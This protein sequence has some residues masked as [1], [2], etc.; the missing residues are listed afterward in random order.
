MF[1]FKAGKDGLLSRLL[2]R[3]AKSQATPS[4]ERISGAYI[5][6]QLP[7]HQ[8]HNSVISGAELNTL[9]EQSIEMKSR[10]AQLV[11]AKIIPETNDIQL[12]ES[13]NTRGERRGGRLRVV[14]LTENDLW[15]SCDSDETRKSQQDTASQNGE[16]SDDSELTNEMA[17][18]FQE[19]EATEGKKRKEILDGHVDKIFSAI[20]HDSKPALRDVG[21]ERKID[22]VIFQMPEAAFSAE[23]GYARVDFREK[24]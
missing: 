12:S 19:I 7:Q 3:P 1:T 9:Q 14:N 5:P 20:D 24:R 22:I 8:S 11:E 21:A 15:S 17:T 23:V 18:L 13:L 2:R 6:R 4:I 16:D 10:A